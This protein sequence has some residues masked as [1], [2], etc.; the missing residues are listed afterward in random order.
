MCC[1]FVVIQH[2]LNILLNEV[3]PDPDFANLQVDNMFILRKSYWTNPRNQCAKGKT[4]I[5]KSMIS[6]VRNCMGL[7]K[8]KT[9]RVH[10][11]SNTRTCLLASSIFIYTPGMSLYGPKA[12]ITFYDM[13]KI[14]VVFTVYILPLKKLHYVC[15][16][17]H[18]I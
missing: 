8:Q 9:P 13:D 17:S 11:V 14:L 4:V 10:A 16:R 5:A 18:N 15:I 1:R 2:L 3:F 6:C 7:R 12:C